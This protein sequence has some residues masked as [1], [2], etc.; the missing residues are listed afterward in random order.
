MKTRFQ[1]MTPCQ[2]WLPLCAILICIA[3][4]GCSSTGS[5]QKQS[6]SSTGFFGSKIWAKIVPNK[7]PYG[8]FENDGPPDYN[9]NLDSIP[10]ATP[11]DEPLARY[12]NMP[13]YTV[14]GK[15]Y[16][17]MKTSNGYQAE[18]YASWYGKKWHG[19]KTSSGERYDVA[20][21]TAAHR[22][23]PLPTYVKVT[24]LTNGKKVVVKVNDRG[25]FHSSRIID[26]SYAAAAK[27]GIVAQGT[28][29]VMVEAISTSIKAE[30]SIIAK[31]ES[32]FKASK[33]A[34]KER[35]LQLGSFSI[36]ENALSLVKDI[37]QLTNKPV[38]VSSIVKENQSFYQVKVGPFVT[39]DDA[40]PLIQ[41][42][43]SLG[44]GKPILT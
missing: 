28:A 35:Y 16:T 25:P 11:K 17:T 9:I 44:L 32:L 19:R 27:L 23:L 20:G 24:N 2:K 8:Y 14:N 12:G 7:N 10:D 21:M 18:G 33:Q 36:R 26:L 41:S 22:S 29:K 42:I 43:N 1:P 3:L 5:S 31:G 37:E 30:Q 6:A 38:Q 34:A 15:N 13:S 4:T 39:D 40:Q